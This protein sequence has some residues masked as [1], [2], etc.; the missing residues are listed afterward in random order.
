MISKKEKETYKLFFLIF[1]INFCINHVSAWLTP[2]SK[3]DKSNRTAFLHYFLQGP[4]E[5]VTSFLHYFETVTASEA[6][7]V[8]LKKDFSFLGFFNRQCL[9]VHE[10]LQQSWDELVTAI[11][12]CW[13]RAALWSGLALQRL[14]R[15]R[16]CYRGNS[17]LSLSF[18]P[19]QTSDIWLHYWMRFWYK[20]LTTSFHRSRI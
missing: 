11:L 17:I 15:P 20:C 13:G 1:L 6:F 14:P 2:E 12:L 5:L 9:R 16:S 8:T 19:C 18:S 3:R 7:E 10:Q 4:A